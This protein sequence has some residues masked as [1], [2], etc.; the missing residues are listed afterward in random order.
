MLTL[1]GNNTYSGGSTIQNG[2]LQLG[3]TAAL[4]AGPLAVNG[5]TLDM[6]GY[7]VTAPSFSGAAGTITN[8]ASNS[9]ATLSVNQSTNTAFNG[10]IADGAGQVGLYK[11]GPGMLTLGNANAYSGGTAIAA[12]TLQLG[13]TAAL[14]SGALAANG[15]M[16]DMAGYGATVSSFSG[17]SGVVTNSSTGTL[18]TLT[19]NQAI[20]TTFSGQLNDAAGQVG[21][22][23]T[24]AGTL[25]LN[26]VNDY[27]GPTTVNAGVLY[28]GKAGALSTSSAV[29]INNGTLDASGYIQTIGSL[30]MTSTAA[31]LNLGYGNMLTC[32]G[33]APDNA[34]A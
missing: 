1:A 32:S 4:G 33:F 20:N 15:G 6:A 3:N 25:T 5:G 19:V 27:S 14:G 7:S 11:S 31:A 24:G 17:A 13:N 18:A 2:T 9:L 28:T 22:Y 10:T 29:T 8:S 26:N 23:K 12:G 21:L 16:L 34:G 30:M